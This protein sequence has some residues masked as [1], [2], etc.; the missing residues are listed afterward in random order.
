MQTEASPSPTISI[1]SDLFDPAQIDK[2]VLCIEVAK[3]RFRFLVLDANRHGCWLED[4]TF[5]SLLSERPIT[6]ALSA[7]FQQH[8]LLQSSDT[9]QPW[10]QVRVSLNSTSFTLIPTPLFRK[11]YA[12]SYLS[13]VRGGALPTHEYAQA[14]AHEE[15]F[16]SVFNVE[17]AL[18]EYFSATY[19]L[20]TITF[21]HQTSALIR[22][23]AAHPQTAQSLCLYFEDEFVTILLRADGKLTYCNRFGFK[24]AQDLTYYV[25][26]VIDELALESLSVAI[27]LYGEIT[28]FADTF[29][30]LAQFLPHLTF[31]HTPQGLTLSADFNDLP[32]HRYL[33]L[34]GL[35]L[36]NG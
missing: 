11:E 33:S 12:S 7:L 2:S 15:G 13:L 14:Y 28:P 30:R 9:T 4:Y 20:Q 18:S 3:D 29:A 27:L 10:Q 21:V 22:A 34:Y 8:P 16:Y 19:P 5:S 35:A 17:Y 26:Y 32:E 23:T 25:L 1:R 6:E 31:G 36:L 24:N